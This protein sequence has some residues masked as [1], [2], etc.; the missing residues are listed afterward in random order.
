MALNSKQYEILGDFIVMLSKDRIFEISVDYDDAE[1]FAKS[2]VDGFLKNI[3]RSEDEIPPEIYLYRAV[4]D[5]QE[6][7]KRIEDK[8]DL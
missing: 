8:T 4:W 3:D 1:D 7:I 2:L 5:M 6:M